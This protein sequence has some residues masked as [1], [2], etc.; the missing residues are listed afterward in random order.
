VRPATERSTT[1]TPCPGDCVS[2]LAL[3]QGSSSSFCRTVRLLDCSARTC[4]IPA[5]TEP[6]ERLSTSANGSVASWQCFGPDQV[7][8]GARHDDGTLTETGNRVTVPAP[9]APAAVALF[10]LE[11]GS[12]D[13]GG[14]PQELGSVTIQKRLVRDSD[15]HPSGG[16]Q[17]TDDRG[18]I[19]CPDRLLRA[20]AE[21]RS[22]G[23]AGAGQTAM[24]TF[25]PNEGGP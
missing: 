16:L 14:G 4:R 23:R 18:P 24:V 17:S 5:C 11:R 9:E 19:S 8:R 7:S 20:H 21:L 13:D 10:G 6:K 1:I 25:C 12:C 22:P 15:G 3:D 2:P